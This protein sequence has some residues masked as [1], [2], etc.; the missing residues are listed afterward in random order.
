MERKKN[1]TCW[2]DGFSAIHLDKDPFQ[3]PYYLG[4]LMGYSV[5]VLYPSFSVNKD[6]PS[7]INGVKMISVRTR[8]ELAQRNSRFYSYGLYLYLIKHSKEIDV[9]MTFFR[10]NSACI[11]YK[12]FNPKG[13]VY[14]KGDVNP[15]AIKKEDF[16]GL[17][18]I[19]SKT[20]RDK[21]NSIVD[22]FS[23]ETTTALK[24]YGENGKGHYNWE[25]RLIT[26]PNGYD[27]ELLKT[28]NIEEKRFDQKENLM[29]TVGRLGTYPKNTEMLLEA[30]SKVDFKGW[31][32]ILI[33]PIESSF[34]PKIDTFYQTYPSSK[35]T[36]VFTGAIRDKAALWEY[37][38]RSKL[39]LLPSRFESY[40]IV[41][42]EALR[43]KNYILA[44]QV[45][46]MED[47]LNS[48]DYGQIIEQENA[49]DLARKIQT[50][51]DGQ[52]DIAH[53]FDSFVTQSVS[54]EERLKELAE[55]LSI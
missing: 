7:E 42:N 54:W 13:K 3:V 52:V 39:F 9:F 22:C 14:I 31:R 21:L 17:K 45:G 36:I 33:G 1:I 26:L 43:F 35:E 55:K 4:K 32:C 5:T 29:I 10:S 53:K 20:K 24:K 48:G 41:F 34:L 18:G 37:Y 40:A 44:T 16:R 25:E 15:Y 51:V 27:E 28:F 46:A 23:V 50:I 11:L 19:L 49:D 8:G 6:M 12:L 47:I 30:L 38:N 2:F